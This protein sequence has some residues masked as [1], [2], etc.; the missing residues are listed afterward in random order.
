MVSDPE[1]VG[2]ELSILDD[3]PSS[4]PPMGS[5]F[6]GIVCGCPLHT[7]SGKRCKSNRQCGE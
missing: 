6:D 7:L 5:V 3:M 1:S 4:S 2:V